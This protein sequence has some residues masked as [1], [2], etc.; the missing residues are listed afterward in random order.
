M[1]TETTQRFPVAAYSTATC[2][3]LSL[4]VTYQ[5]VVALNARLH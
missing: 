2:S 1:N 5:A 3:L 4:E